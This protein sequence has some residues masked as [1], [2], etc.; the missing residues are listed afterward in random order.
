MQTFAGE[1]SF[2]DAQAE[3]DVDDNE[4][5]KSPA[6][7]AH[8]EIET[9]R[10][11]G[12]NRGKQP[13]QAER[14]IAPKTVFQSL[15]RQHP[16]DG[17]STNPAPIIRVHGTATV[18]RDKAGKQ[19]L[20][21]SQGRKIPTHHTLLPAKMDDSSQRS[22]MS[23]TQEN[24]AS[25]YKHFDMQALDNL[26][27]SSGLAAEPLSLLE[28]PASD[29]QLPDTQADHS[30]QSNS[31]RTQSTARTYNE[32]DT[33]HINFDAFLPQSTADES[34]MESQDPPV[35][36]ALEEVAEEPRLEPQTPAPS[37]NPFSEK[38]SVMKGHELFGATQP[39]SIGRLGGS[40]TS[41]RPSPD[42]YND[43]RTPQNF[44]SSPLVR[45]SDL[46]AKTSQH[47]ARSLLR[48]LGADPH[49]R[50]VADTS[51]GIQ[52][53]DSALRNLS[54][55]REPLNHYISMKESQERRRKLSNNVVSSD[56]DS[57]SDIE[58]VP[59]QYRKIERERK[60]QQ[61]MSKVG[62][63]RPFASG[64]TSALEVKKNLMAATNVRSSTNPLSSSMEDQSARTPEVLAS[65]PTAVEVPST[66]RRR[67][68]Q[69]DY[70][71]QCEGSDARDTQPQ[72]I[73]ADSQ[74][75]PNLTSVVESSPPNSMKLPIPLSVDAEAEATEQ[76]TQGQ[77]LPERSR[78]PRSPSPI[79]DVEQD[80][81]SR[82]V[83]GN[84]SLPSHEESSPTKAT[85]EEPRSLTP[86]RKLNPF[87]DGVLS[88]VPETSPALDRVKPM[89]EIASISFSGAQDDNYD[90]L[91]EFSQDVEFNEA[92]GLPSHKESPLRKRR[93]RSQIADLPSAGDLVPSGS[94]S[95]GLSSAPSVL[96]PPTPS[97]EILP[98][99]GMSHQPNNATD[100]PQNHSTHP[101]TISRTEPD[102]KEQLEGNASED[103]LIVMNE[104]E[105]EATSSVE[106]SDEPMAK[107]QRIV[108]QD[109]LP[110]LPRIKPQPKATKAVT[111][112]KPKLGIPP[113]EAPASSRSSTPL[114][115]ADTT[116]TSI[117]ATGSRRGRSASNIPKNTIDETPVPNEAKRVL[118][119][120]ATKTV[121]PKKGAFPSR[122][123]KRKSMMPSELES[124]D[125]LALSSPSTKPRA[126]AHMF[127]NM[128]FAV[129][130]V[131]EEKEKDNVTRL[132]KQ[133]GG[134]LLDDGFEKLFTPIKTPTKAHPEDERLEL[135]IAPSEAN[136]GFVALIADEHSRKAKYMQALALGLPCISGRWI[137]DC[138]SKSSIIDWMPYLLSSGQSS[139]LGGAIKSRYL[140]PYSAADATL[141]DTFADRP[142][143]LEGKSVLIITGRGQVEEKRK[144]YTFLTRALGADRVGQ[145]HDVAGAKKMLLE[146]EK[147]GEEFD[148]LYVDGKKDVEGAIFDS[149]S[150]PL[151][152]KKRKRAS[153]ANADAP[154]PKRVRVV[155]DE[156]IIQS[157]ILGQ[158][159]EE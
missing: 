152:G 117:S 48:S 153:G 17:R 144:P 108:T 30:K 133:H 25:L 54:T 31:A 73:I 123:S 27:L 150:V 121:Q 50:V 118:K 98:T 111:Q 151:A 156:I 138:I 49:V 43:I 82:R 35:A 37:V 56:S 137:H 70:I 146:A 8:E 59:R 63:R 130:Y 76:E 92:M 11:A 64:S 12:V 80:D 139:F 93:Y 110:T 148:W 106:H 34:L 32:D 6:K 103:P 55:T 41:S 39:S 149:T 136:V 9:P 125:P 135:E 58:S 140:H 79:Q 84:S 36:T 61:E 33:G 29:T 67:S 52:S 23:L 22:A 14:R 68:I 13:D 105:P 1:C 57:D 40:P 107:R 72:D 158:L 19:R 5:H 155:N 87:S 147:K 115:T 122:S 113:I 74:G 47:P 100:D 124:D 66:N 26:I 97:P 20:Y 7:D 16:N 112:S 95:S 102:L 45:H 114:S 21:D 154:V 132:I 104:E 159:I 24:P 60:I 81:S 69:E 157:L 134:R 15:Q 88:T 53:F 120:K 65:A 3:P 145:A 75:A 10:A 86:A 101:E 91:P 42:I 38:G 78:N 116:I 94:I 129:S 44:D 4:N 141:S 109:E 46:V 62:L 51:S 28:E 83:E 96:E 90:D 142:K 131:G 128:V 18:R 71:A 89:A 119:P 85:P 126:A 127:D 143:L 2:V 77:A 99:P